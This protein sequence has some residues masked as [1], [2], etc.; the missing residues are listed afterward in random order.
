MRGQLTSLTV[1]SENSNVLGFMQLYGNT[2]KFIGKARG[3]LSRC[4]G[5]PPA[6]RV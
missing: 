5:L 4:V 1:V 6:R 3:R 2:A